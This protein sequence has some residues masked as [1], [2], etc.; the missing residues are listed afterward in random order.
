MRALIVSDIH[1]NLEALQAVLEDAGRRGGFD[2][3]WALGDLVGYGPDPGP[4]LDILREHDVVAVAGNHD[5]AAVGKLGTEAFNDYAAAAVHWTA[6]QLDEEQKSYLRELPLRAEVE[7]FTLVHG[8][9]RDPVWEYVVTPWSA[10]AN[11]RHFETDRCLVGHSHIP[12]V[13]RQRDD[14]AVFSS[15]PPDEPVPLDAERVIMNPGGLGQPRD[16]DPRTTYAVYDSATGAI[17]HHRVEYDI[18]KTQQKILESGLPPFLA[19]RLAS[20]R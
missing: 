17:S 16:G 2:Q 5:L 3:V 20:G 19:A 11:F 13:C 7:G 12:F 14:T 18:P 15:F 6:V 9:P 10:A 1:S 8:S 4:C